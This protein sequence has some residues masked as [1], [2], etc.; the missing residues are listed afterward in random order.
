MSLRTSAVHCRR[1][2]QG[3]MSEVVTALSEM[4]SVLGGDKC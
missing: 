1:Q 2:E 4:N 3:T